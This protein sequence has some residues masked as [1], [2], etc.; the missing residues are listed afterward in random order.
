MPE[1]LAP[2]A[3][4]PSIHVH[5]GIGSIGRG[6]AGGNNGSGHPWE[7]DPGTNWGAVDRKPVYRGPQ[8]LHVPSPDLPITCEEM[9]WLEDDNAGRPGRP[10]RLRVYLQIH[11]IDLSRAR[12]LKSGEQH[13]LRPA[14]SDSA[15]FARLRNEILVLATYGDIIEC[16]LRVLGLRPYDRS[17]GNFHFAPLS[18]YDPRRMGISV[19]GDN[20]V[21]VGYPRL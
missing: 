3:P 19:N 15:V 5:L 8:R 6:T 17:L 2:P 10:G 11:G 16:Q 4:A 18:N 21:T 14:G 7:E 12:F 9:G 1:R 20:L 13:Y